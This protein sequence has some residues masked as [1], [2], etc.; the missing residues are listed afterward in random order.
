MRSLSVW[1]LLLG[2]AVVLA[3]FPSTGAAAGAELITSQTPWRV[4]LVTGLRIDKG[5]D[6]QL[7]V[8]QRGPNRSS[9]PP[10][11]AQTA[12]LSDPPPANWTAGDFDD[13]L[14]GRYT[15]D[16]SEY[17]GGYGCSVDDGGGPAIYPAMLCLRTRFGI[18]D[19]SQARDLKVAVEYLGGV[20]VSV[21]G[22][23]VARS[24]LPD[25]KAD[26]MALATDYPIEAYTVE[27]GTTPLPGLN[28]RTQPE[29]KW[30]SRYQARV[31]T[32][33]ATIPAQALVKGPNALALSIHR[34]AIRGPLPRRCAWSHLGIRGVKL[35]SA[36]GAGAIAYADATRG[37][38]VWSAQACDQVT[39]KPSPKSLIA[40]DWF[41]DAGLRGMPLKGIAVGN[42]FDPVLAVRIHAPRNGV[43][44]GQTVL[45]DPSGL[46]QV[47][48]LLG[49]LVGP[50]GAVLSARSVSVRFAA[51]GADL[52][53]C[54][55]LVE[56]APEGVT[57]LPV[58]VQVEPPRNQAPGWY[59]ATLALHAN[60]REFQV[61]VQVL[62][63]GLTMPD[64]R[65]FRSL[66]G[67]MHSPDT[68]AAA[69]QVEPWSQEHFKLMA[70]SVEM[71]AQLGNDIMY[72]PVMVGSHM[73]HQTGLIRWVKTA[74]GLRP[75]YSAFEQY[76]DLYLKY[77]A[78][79]KG[80]SLYVWSQT[81]AKEVANAY[82]GRAIVTMASNPK[83]TMQVTQWDP[84]T[85]ANQSITVPTFLDD[86]A[87]AFWKP[88]LDGVRQIVQ[89]RGWSE[90]VIMLGIASDTRPSQ[91]TG[92]LLREWAPYA[93]W[94]IYSHFSADPAVG[95]GRGFFYKGPPLPGSAPGKMIAIGNLEVGMKEV[96]D[97]GILSA[98]AMERRLQE[99]IEFLHL[100]IHRL[101]YNDQTGPLV[102]R[103]LPCHAPSIARV[104]LDFWSGGGGG[105]IWGGFATRLA[106]RRPDGPG[107]TVR[108]AL[109][110]QGMQ[111]YEA[112]L[113]L[114][115]SLAKLPEQQQK[116]YRDLFDDLVR[117]ERI[118]GQF[119]SQTELGLD[120]SSYVSQVYRAAE[121]LTGIKAQATWENPP[122]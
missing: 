20:V 58:W 22:V 10:I 55:D 77:C 1:V 39:E 101:V 28:F 36:T 67:V 25:G 38:R 19:P 95:G 54:D 16:L 107:P 46:R 48:A 37:A 63:T 52:H 18:A 85:R 21:N 30:A 94:D 44:L 33:T 113:T 5:T 88:M 73:K 117:R 26:A 114:L 97:G 119:L 120:F 66:I 109:M 2:G 13:H 93:R 56:R 68:L 92:E 78:P 65:D 79:P 17:I 3:A 42:P 23:E 104:G 71:A 96:P 83:A 51:Q 45:S 4:W 103:T 110:R 81:S 90:R 100:S 53:W 89:K 7:T 108:L 99:K 50:G 9:P 11:N 29:E 27:D 72:V 32:M 74:G 82:E 34:S 111:D 102:F 91:K 106:T 49:D 70:K 86:G 75:D 115:E 24:H 69:Y 6:G 35:T 118:G 64:P 15:D 80:I 84:T 14:W 8:P 61:P 47:K 43:G 41:K 122:R 98:A 121:E 57:T 112:R 12:Q 31:R 76:L 87:Q 60:G 105:L 59:V 62:V 40:R 116:P